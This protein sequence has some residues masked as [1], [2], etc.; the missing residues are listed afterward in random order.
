M[1]VKLLLPSSDRNE[2]KGGEK[3][4]KPYSTPK[5]TVHGSIESI[6][7]GV[8]PGR[9]TDDTMPVTLGNK[10]KLS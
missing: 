7:Q 2:W 5:L 8:A 6:T 3:M 4:K 1:R 10:R 9:A